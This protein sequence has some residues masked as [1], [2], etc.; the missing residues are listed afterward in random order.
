MGKETAIS[1]VDSTWNPWW[2]CQKV[3][4]GCAHCYAETFAN[5]VGQDIWGADHAFRFFGDKH[6][7]E[8]EKWDRDAAAAGARRR[9][10]CASMADVFEDRPELV[11]PRERL[12]D[13]IRR[14]PNLDWLVLTKRAQEM[15]DYFDCDHGGAPVFECK[16][17]R[18]LPNL[19]LGVSVENQRQAGRI[20][21][22][23]RTP[24]AVR[25]VSA[26]PLLGPLTNGDCKV[27]GG[28]GWYA[29]GPSDKPEQVGCSACLGSGRAGVDF[30]GIDWVIIGGE[31]GP[32]HRPMEV[33]WALGVIDLAHD[34]GAAVF[35]KQAGGPRPGMQGDLP[36]W[37]FAIREWPLP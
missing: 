22:L 12:F 5:R 8:P 24:A 27:C 29:D 3:S 15:H 36:D 2:G 20:D 21:L 19:W 17:C 18:P 26:E 7:A 25:F 31:S 10:F 28:Q 33:E 14:T 16:D 30:I 32:K 13:L 1:W 34:A 11:E 9:V 35:V 37:A 4:P 23:V 6:W